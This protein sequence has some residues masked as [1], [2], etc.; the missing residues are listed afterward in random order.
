MENIKSYYK[1]TKEAETPLLSNY[2]VQDIEKDFWAFY[3]DN[4]QIFD[5]YFSREYETFVFGFRDKDQT[6]AEN[7]AEFSQAVKDL[8][9]VNHKKYEELW[10]VETVDDDSYSM[11]ENYDLTEHLEKE[12]NKGQ[13]TN[14]SNTTEG[15]QTDNTTLTYGDK[16]E[17]TTAQISPEDDE[18]WRNRD[19]ATTQ[20]TAQNDTQQTTKGARTDTGSTTEGARTDG[21]E[22]TLTRKGN[23]GVQTATQVMQL[24]DDFWKGHNFYKVIFNDIAAAY[25]LIGGD[26]WY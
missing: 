18:A 10:R 1:I 24:H 8:L 25:L 20:N 19:K 11:L 21:E 16:T 3:R 26:L 4:Y 17:T 5:R 12:L 7:A 23:I 15:A 9:T 2:S 13:Q 22:Y 14:T 6:T